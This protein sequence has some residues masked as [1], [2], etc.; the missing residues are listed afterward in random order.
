MKHFTTTFLSLLACSVSGQTVTG[1]SEKDFFG[2][3]PVVLSVSRLPQRLDET[4]GAVT[5]IDRQM[6]RMSGARD[7]ADLLRLVPGFRV[8]NSFESNTPQGTYHGSWG[9]YANRVQVMVDGRSVYSPVLQGSTGPG[10][11][12]VALDD[13]ERIEVVRGSNSASYGARAFL[14]TVNIVTLSPLDTQGTQVRLG[15]GDNGIQDGKLRLGWGDDRASFRI[16]ADRREDA[17]LFGASGPARVSRANFRGDFFPVPGDQLEL[18]LGQSLIEAGVGFASQEGNAPRVRLIDTTYGQ[19]DWRRSLSADQDVLVQFAHTSD[20]HRDE[21]PY[22]LIPG[23]TLDFGGSARS[24]NLL[25]QHSLRRSEDMRLVWGLE[26]RREAVTSRPLFD[27]GDPYTSDFA[28]AFGNVELRWAKNWLLNAGAMVERNSYGGEHLAPRFMLNWHPSAGHT[29]RAGISS[30]FRPPSAY[31]KFG[32]TRYYYPAGS[33]LAGNLIGVTVGALGQAGSERVLSR[34][35]GYFGDFPGR[36]LNF[37]VRLFHEEVRDMIRAN[38]YVSA[39][40]LQPC[41]PNV[42]STDFSNTENFDIRGVEFQANWFPWSGG[43]LVLG[44]A[45]VDSGWD[46]GGTFVGAERLPAHRSSSLMLMQDLANGVNLS[47]L[48]YQASQANFPG[49]A[50]PLAPATSRTDVRIAKALRLG[51]Q[52]GELSFVVQNLGPTYQ[53]FIPEFEFRR[54]AFVMLKLEN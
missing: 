6:I 48:H 19:I 27:R 4:P 23:L 24:D 29:L 12:S 38:G 32:N 45:Y 47:L 34:E 35:V 39:T 20:R 46:D 41:G 5:V 7:V 49:T 8:S 17:G 25:L 31:E 16:S 37:D 54:Q 42:C 14:G 52:R 22:S 40:G 50:R 15:G 30:A 3:V 44:H 18:R 10:L 9:D 26:L 1:V 13:I 11:Q 43:R 28:R 2:D 21:F 53:D 33:P 51:Q 36:R